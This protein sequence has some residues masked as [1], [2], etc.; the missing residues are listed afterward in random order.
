MKF[1]TKIKQADVDKYCRG[2]LTLQEKKIAWHLLNKKILDKDNIDI[3][4]FKKLK[5]LP[6]CEN[7]K[8]SRIELTSLPDLPMCKDLYCPF[9]ELS[10]LPKL[11]KCERLDCSYNRLTQLPELPKCKELD[12]QKNQLTQLPDL[13][14]CELLTCNNNELSQLPKLPKCE[15]LSCHKNKLTQ[16][17]KFPKCEKINC[18]FN[19]LTQLPELQK[20]I[21]LDCSEN[22][23][24]QLPELPQ[25]E[26]LTCNK[27]QLIQLPELPNCVLLQC[28]YNQLR[29]LPDLPK[30]YTLSC[31][32]NQLIELPSLPSCKFLN[33]SYN[34]L[35]ELPNLPYLTKLN[36]EG[37]PGYFPYP[38]RSSQQIN[39]QK[40]LFVLRKF[41]NGQATTQD[42]HKVNKQ[43]LVQFIHGLDQRVN[44]QIEKQDLVYWLQRQKQKRLEQKR[45]GGT[46]IQQQ[47]SNT[48]LFGNEIVNPVIGDDGV[49]Y[50]RASLDYYFSKNDNGEYINIK[51]IYNDSYQVVPNYVFLGGSK[52]LTKYKVL[53]QNGRLVG[54]W[55]N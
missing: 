32:D 43:T 9:N 39:K 7:L 17:P 48:D 13:P 11:P 12:C 44:T 55:L 41:L 10:Q 33:C 38:K 2:P 54:H 16:L 31:I 50:D 51:Y 27:N 22:Q 14:K 34:Y 26:Y 15:E 18:S 29:E 53:G 4:I 36:W 3:K 5:L 37:N 28:S 45:T 40:Q 8:C 6:E 30:C 20:C 35:T 23:L 47:S 19:V 25:C 52:P 46:K 1:E 49:I 21:E 42:L 24:I